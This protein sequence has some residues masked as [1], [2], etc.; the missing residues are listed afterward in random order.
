[1]LEYYES[2]MDEDSMESEGAQP[3]VDFIKEIGAWDL[4]FGEQSLY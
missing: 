2:C 3:L 4:L 1:M